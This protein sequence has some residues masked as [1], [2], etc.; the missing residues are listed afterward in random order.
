MK[1][2]KVSDWIARGEKLFGKSLRDWL[3]VCPMCWHVQGGLEF[4]ERTDLEIKNIEKVLGFSCIGRY[5]RNQEPKPRQR[6]GAM[7]LK[8][9]GGGCNWTLGGLFQMH[10]ASVI[11]DDGSEH[12]IF[13]FYEKEKKNENT[14]Q[15][16]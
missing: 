11:L 16:R 6:E 12:Q 7:P 10:K 1:K 9:K 14:K 15:N 8:M 13:E 3:F 4:Q 2:E 5:L